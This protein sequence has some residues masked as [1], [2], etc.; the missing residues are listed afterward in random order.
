MVETDPAAK[1]RVEKRCQEIVETETGLCA[2]ILAL[3]EKLD[4]VKQV[5]LAP[6]WMRGMAPRSLSFQARSSG[7]TLRFCS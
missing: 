3:T 4:H 2:S 5:R 6:H 1:E 7:A